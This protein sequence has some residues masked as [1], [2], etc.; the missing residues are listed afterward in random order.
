MRFGGR[1]EDM[2]SATKTVKRLGIVGAAAV[3]GLVPI[4]V[5]STSAYAVSGASLTL[6]STVPGQ[7]TSATNT[8]TVTNSFAGTAPETVTVTAN[9]GESLPSSLVDYSVTVGGTADSLT[10]VSSTPGGADSTSTLAL[11][12]AATAGQQVVVT[13][14]GVVDPTASPSSVYFTDQ[15]SSDTNLPAA[16]TNIVTVAGASAASPVV[17]SVNPTAFAA[18]SDGAAG[19]T[20][21][22]IGATPQPTTPG[23]QFTVMG[24]GFATGTGNSVLVCF[25]PVG[26]TAPAGGTTAPCTTAS[27]PII[28]ATT[29]FS[30]ST[31]LQGS[32]TNLA[33]GSKYNAV[34][35]NDNG[36]TYTAASTTSANTVVAASASTAPANPNISNSGALNFVTESGVR[37]VDTRVGLGLPASALTPGTPYFIPSQTF[38]NSA[39]VPTNVPSNAT[40]VALNVTATAPAGAG[41]IQVWSPATASSTGCSAHPDAASTV[42]FQPPQDTNNSTIVSLENGVCVQD[43]GAP[44]NVVMDVTGYTTTSTG[45]TA[46]GQSFLA[47]AMFLTGNTGAN[48]GQYGSRILDTRPGATDAIPSIQGPL[49]G[50]TVYRFNAVA[51]SADST[52]PLADG[53]VVALNVTAVG[54]TSAGN[55]RVFPEPSTGAPAPSGVPNVAADTYIPGMDG[56]SL[57]ITTVGADGYIDLYSDSAGT[58]N[59]VIDEVG[60]FSSSPGSASSVTGITPVRMIDTRPGGVAAGAMTTFTAAPFAAIPTDVPSDALAVFGDLADIQPTS[61]GYL[62]AYPA[63]ETMP[64]TANIANYPGQTRSTTAFAAVNPSNGQVSVSSVG[65]MTNFTFDA[66]AFVS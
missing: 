39:A 17:S 57:V 28:G 35:Y 60:V 30:N 11:T 19:T 59:V 27:T 9:G 48:S 10:G 58:V 42:N 65:A 3:V 12:N 46:G 50:G 7:T 16:N 14:T 13:V 25:V 64:G 40:A 24:S 56:G 4:G 55:L 29:F 18:G 54:P 32:V 22:E 41:N 52:V 1:K 63:G 62:V 51:G 6:A 15:A 33:L 45:L 43:N 5:L 23:E 31:E 38:E 8:F 49:A 66:T 47:P 21:A 37:A 44:V 20:P 26:T 61:P 34:A 2:T 53:A 36:G